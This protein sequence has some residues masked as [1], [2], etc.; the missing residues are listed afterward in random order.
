MKKFIKIFFT[1][2]VVFL[3]LTGKAFGQ[4]DIIFQSIPS[5]PYGKGS[6]IAVLFNPKG[7]FPINNVFELY[8]SDADGNFNSAAANTA[9]GSATTHYITYINGLIPANASPSSTYKLKI[10]AKSGASTLI[11]KTSSF[12]INIQNNTSS[13]N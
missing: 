11:S 4:H 12:T 5:G 8:L 1:L 9:I 2:G 13:S 6:S 10:I 3:S 7:V